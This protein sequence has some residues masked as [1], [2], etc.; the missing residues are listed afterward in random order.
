MDHYYY[1]KNKIKELR[2]TRGVDSLVNWQFEFSSVIGLRYDLINFFL[3]NKYY[4]SRT[5]ETLLGAKVEVSKHM[6]L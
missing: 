4:S 6:S 2:I 5:I 3:C 1:D